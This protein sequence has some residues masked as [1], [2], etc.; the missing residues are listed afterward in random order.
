MPCPWQASSRPGHETAKDLAAN[1]PREVIA[2]AIE[3]SPRVRGRY[4]FTTAPSRRAH[5]LTHRRPQRVNQR[6]AEPLGSLNPAEEN[7]T[8]RIGISLHSNW[9]IESP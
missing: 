3:P 5:A 6:A 2:S 8:M 7:D 9:G 4:R 1:S